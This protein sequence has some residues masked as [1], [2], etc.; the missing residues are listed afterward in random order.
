MNEQKMAPGKPFRKGHWLAKKTFDI[1]V[2]HDAMAFSIEPLDELIR[3]KFGLPDGTLYFI[4]YLGGFNEP[5]EPDSPP[6]RVY[7]AK[8]CRRHESVEIWRQ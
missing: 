8:C 6:A 4:N 2:E 7:V 5:M 3:H 1:T